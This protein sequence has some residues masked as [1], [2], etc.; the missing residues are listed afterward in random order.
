MKETKIR[1]APR[2]QFS[3]EELEIFDLLT[4][5][6]NLTKAEEQKVILSSKN[7]FKK[8]NENRSNLFVADWYRGEQPKA[9]V[10]NAIMETLD[11]DLPDSYDK[12]V[13]IVKTELLLNHFID[14]AVQGYGW[15]GSV[16]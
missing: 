4:K 14:M 16:A 7:L 1:A 8:L 3:E 12:E 5:G 2:L 11:A 6:K 13:F 10:K 9:R 15:V